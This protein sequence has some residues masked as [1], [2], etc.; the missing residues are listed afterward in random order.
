ME[1]EVGDQYIDGYRPITY[2]LHSGESVGDDAYEEAK[3]LIVNMKYHAGHENFMNGYDL[4]KKE[5]KIK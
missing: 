3:S 4:N 5:F 1:I 2:I